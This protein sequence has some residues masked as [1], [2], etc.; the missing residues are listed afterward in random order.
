[1]ILINFKIYKETFGD[2]A[3]EL[4]KIC[5]SVME[6]TGVRIIPVVSALDV[7][8]ISKEVGIEV[9][10][11]STDGSVEGAKTGYV[12]LEQ[13][14]MAGASGST[15][16]HSEHKL[17]PGTIKKLIS[18]SPTDFKSIVCLQSWGQIEG[19]AKSIK[20]TMIAYEPSELIGNKE[21]S[22]AS[23][24]PEMI[25]KIV[26]HYKDI[27]VLVGAGIH[28][29]EDIQVSLELGAK[30]FILATDVVKA[31]D[32]EKELV[33]LAEAFRAYT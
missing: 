4:A 25:K 20:P 19:W 30:G 10:I 12:A 28:S 7:Y 15:I 13:A 29:K 11:Q 23:E 26:E 22:V 14:K 18:S 17:K 3:V 33:E 32:P 21:K 5:K 16:N 8:R 6:K 24:K 1:M 9:L 27:P 31:E 2:K